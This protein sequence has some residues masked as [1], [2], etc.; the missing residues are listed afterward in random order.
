MTIDENL[1][2][3]RQHVNRLKRET[4]SLKAYQGTPAERDRAARTMRTA[5]ELANMAAYVAHQVDALATAA[6]RKMA[7]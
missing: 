5:M 7:S 4:D 6:E 1:E 3:I 2:R